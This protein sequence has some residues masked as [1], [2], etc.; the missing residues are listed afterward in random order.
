MHNNTEFADESESSQ[1]GSI[2]SEIIKR[3]EERLEGLALT[4]D[5]DLSNK[6]VVALRIVRLSLSAGDKVLVFSHRPHALVSPT[7]PI[8]L[9]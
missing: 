2:K 4:S 5:P 3:N 9:L 1:L 8:H 6:Y 7:P